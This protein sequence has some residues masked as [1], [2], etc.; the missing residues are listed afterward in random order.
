MTNRLFDGSIR[1]KQEAEAHVAEHGDEAREMFGRNYFGQAGLGLAG[2]DMKSVQFQS[3]DAEF[4]EKNDDLIFHFYPKEGGAFP[5]D[6]RSRIWNAMIHAFRLGNR[7]ERVEI[8]WISEF[9]S[10]CVTIKSVAVIAAPD[11][12]KIVEALGFVENP[13]AIKEG[14]T[15]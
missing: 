6:F 15:A 11:D 5:D 8:E 7:H 9:S 14:S 12:E 3:F 13:D 4:L 2:V 10:W 1:S